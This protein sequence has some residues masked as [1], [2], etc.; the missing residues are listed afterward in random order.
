MSKRS[1]LQ[2]KLKYSTRHAKR[3]AKQVRKGGKK[4]QSSR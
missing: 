3:K 2:P 4:L 1:L